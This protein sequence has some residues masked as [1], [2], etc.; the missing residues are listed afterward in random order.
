MKHIFI[1]FLVLSVFFSSN[2]QNKPFVGEQNRLV[3]FVR[4]NGDPEIDTPR[5]YYEEMFNGET[6]SFK[7]YFQAVSNN[8]LTINTLFF[9]Q[10]T[11]INS[12]V[13][14]KYCYYCYDNTWK[15]NYPDCKG[16]D[17]ASLF[18]LNIGFMLQELAE[19]LELTGNVPSGVALDSNNDDY[20]D[21]FVIVFRGA[22]RGMGKG[23]HSP[24]VGT[25]SQDFIDTKGEIRL[26]GKQIRDYIITYERNSLET[27]CRFLLS[28]LGFPVQYR[29]SRALP[30]SAGAWDPMDGPLLSYPL[31][32]NRMK[33]TNNNWISEIPRIIEPGT[34]S[35]SSADNAANN[36]YKIQSSDSQ[37]FWMLE[38]R[39]N[40]VAWETNLPESG[41]LIYRVNSNYIGSVTANPEVYLYRKDGNNTNSGN[42]ADA[43]FSNI[44][45]RTTFN[46]TSNPAA[47]LSDGTISNDINISNIS[48][49]GNKVSF[50]VNELPSSVTTAQDESEW[51]IRYNSNLKKLHVYGE[52]V[53][54][55]ILFGISGQFIKSVSG[56][57]TGSIDTADLPYGVYIAQLK[58]KSTTKSLKIVLN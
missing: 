8:K 48:F 12:S 57:T 18:E 3:V 50:T 24:Q 46:A 55:V 14:L 21:N 6:N 39:N 41:L 42:V 29:N 10:N 27:H 37:Q 5:S 26:K 45:G 4:F 36:A 17:I 15:G 53:E 44:N 51:Q 1:F 9:P 13:E 11:D 47:F 28:R 52:G 23:I 43:P 16:S 54:E 19:K 40:T 38:Y 25:V 32:Y 30:R 7:S 31:T 33:Y 35:L 34:Y 58:G 20:I 2:A 22:G 56:Q 49:S